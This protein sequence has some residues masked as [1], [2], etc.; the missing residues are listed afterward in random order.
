MIYD[1]EKIVP[2]IVVFIVLFTFPVWYN[3]AFGSGEGAP[4]PELPAQ[5]KQC[6][7]SKEYMRTQH[8]DL[9]NQW[10]DAVVRSDMR[11]YL[12]SENGAKFEMSL[13]NTCLKCH[14]NKTR[15]CDQCHDYMAVKP[16]CWDCHIAPTE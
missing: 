6:V 2:G 8:M 12:S 7:E 9:L 4:K 15:F 5:E 1:K 10:R 14:P 13:T 11:L 16:Y 3:L